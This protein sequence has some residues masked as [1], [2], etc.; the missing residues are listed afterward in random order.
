M[1]QNKEPLKCDPPGTFREVIPHPGKQDRAVEK[2]IIM[3][4]RFAFFFWMKWQNEL[5]EKEWLQQPAPTLVTIDWHRDMAPPPEEQKKQLRQLDPANLSDV[6]NYVWARFDQTNDG[7]I[8]CAAWLNIIGDVILL[9]NSASEMT[10]TFVDF[11]RNEHRVYEFREYDRFEEFLLSRDDQNIFFDIDLDYFIHG[12]GSTL[13]PETFQRYSD[14]EI[15]NI[16]DPDNAGFKHIL[17]HIDGV[18]IAQEPSYCGGISNS[19]QIMEVVHSQLFDRQHHWKHLSE[20][21]ES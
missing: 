20:E 12:K 6:A 4:H 16:I 1:Y 18:T 8:L 5:R 10:D 14:T 9:K 7:H 19:C 15:K 13:Y 2:A 11:E 21:A 17:P 3:E